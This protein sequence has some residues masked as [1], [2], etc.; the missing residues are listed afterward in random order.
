MTL[1]ILYAQRG[2]KGQAASG[3]SLLSVGLD[4]NTATERSKQNGAKLPHEKTA[5]AR[6]KSERNIEERETLKLAARKKSRTGNSSSPTTK[7]EATTPEPAAEPA[8]KT[9]I[10]ETEKMGK[11]CI[12]PNVKLRG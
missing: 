9:A 10:G 6:R 1:C 11:F 4:A 12:A 2:A 3:L 7:L 5:G 8:A